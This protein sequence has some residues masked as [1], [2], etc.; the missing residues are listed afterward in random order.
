MEND[1]KTFVSKLYSKYRFCA[2]KGSEFQLPNSIISWH[3]VKCIV[4]LYI[5]RLHLLRQNAL[6]SFEG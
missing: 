4:Q 2:T 6:F 3:V 1:A 5:F